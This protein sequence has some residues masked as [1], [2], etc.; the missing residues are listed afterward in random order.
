MGITLP[1]PQLIHRWV[2]DLLMNNSDISLLTRAEKELL[3]Y[4]HA[5]KSKNDIDRFLFVLDRKQTDKEILCNIV[6]LIVAILIS[7]PFAIILMLLIDFDLHA[8]LPLITISL[9]SVAIITIF[10]TLLAEYDKWFG[11]SGYHLGNSYW[12]L[13]NINRLRW[14]IE[15]KDK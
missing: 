6:T 3:S 11:L 7:T 8:Y 13:P 2:T 1:Y 5:A 10:T 12:L 9:F 14:E 4:Y 15:R